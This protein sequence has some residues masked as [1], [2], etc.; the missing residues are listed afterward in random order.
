MSNLDDDVL[1]L[2]SLNDCAKHIIDI[3]CNPQDENGNTKFVLFDI[4]D[5][6]ITT[7]AE[8]DDKEAIYLLKKLKD[9][10]IEL[11][12][13]STSTAPM[14]SNFFLKG[15][16]IDVDIKGFG[17]SIE[18]DRNS[19][20]KMI[21]SIGSDNNLNIEQKKAYIDL[22][23]SLNYGNMEIGSRTM[24]NDKN[25][26]ILT[27]YVYQKY[28]KGNQKVDIT[29]LDNDIRNFKKIESDKELSRLIEA[30]L[31]TITTIPMSSMPLE[32]STR[33]RQPIEGTFT[34]EA[35]V[36]E[37]KNIVK[38]EKNGITSSE[39][40]ITFN[41]EKN[42]TKLYDKSLPLNTKLVNPNTKANPPLKTKKHLQK[43]TPLETQ[44][45]SIEVKVHFGL[46]PEYKKDN[47]ILSSYY[48]G[49]QSLSTLGEVKEKFNTR[50]NSLPKPH[51]EGAS[52]EFQKMQKNQKATLGR[53]S[54]LFNKF[55]YEMLKKTDP[56]TNT[57]VVNEGFYINR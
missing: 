36:K 12:I 14:K 47:H 57:G 22:F 53:D 27:H 37:I 23:P 20:E 19:R 31:L 48:K 21:N 13:C 28:L 44:Q 35:L 24:Y 32:N 3:A 42:T 7:G 15:R 50:L 39:K 52:P 56:N 16:D 10:G 46:N 30:K 45:K 33:E 43:K 9:K 41:D 51:I 54:S 29:Y 18:L 38:N 6:I 17:G 26:L 5:C 4:D 11:G 34:T 1:K 25:K 49:K 55:F 40:K 8:E 2:T